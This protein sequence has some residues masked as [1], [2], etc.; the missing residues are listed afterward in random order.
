M[1]KLNG[2]LNV[3]EILRA[4]LNISL[5]YLAVKGNFAV[6]YSICGKHL[7]NKRLPQ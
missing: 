1:V 2:W 5:F 6:F 3:A 7:M 4:F